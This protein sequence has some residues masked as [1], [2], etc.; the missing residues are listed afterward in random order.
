[1]CGF[2]WATAHG[3]VTTSPVS[4][5]QAR[6]EVG[7]MSLAARVAV[8][9]AVAHAKAAPSPPTTAIM[10]G[11]PRDSLRASRRPARDVRGSPARL[12]DLRG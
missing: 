12:P 3:S 2:P 11:Q 1:M 8:I 9:V 5:T 7:G 10:A 6:T 4:I